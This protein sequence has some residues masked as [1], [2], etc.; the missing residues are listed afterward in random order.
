[1]PLSKPGRKRGFSLVEILFVIVL[2]GILM[3][4]IALSGPSMLQ[5]TSGQ[6]EARRM[7]RSL[8]SLR[9][10]WLACYADKQAMPGITTATSS[11]DLYKLISVYSDR[12][13]S[14]ELQRYFKASNREIVVTSGDGGNQIFIGF[15]GEWNLGETIG[16]KAANT[17][18]DILDEQKDLY[19][20]SRNTNGG[21]DT[22]LIRIR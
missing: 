17:M 11:A 4:L 22:I 7:L 12:D 13:L 15:R 8:Q 9:S 5:S 1:M 14:E 18:A 10:A 3:A 19:G 6:T 21:I 20:V 16:N 2:L